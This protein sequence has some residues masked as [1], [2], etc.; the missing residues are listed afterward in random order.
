M[1]KHRLELANDERK[2]RCLLPDCPIGGKPFMMAGGDAERGPETLGSECARC[3]KLRNKL[4]DTEAAWTGL[5]RI[6]YGQ[7]QEILRLRKENEELKKMLAEKNRHDA[8][9][10][11]KNWDRFEFA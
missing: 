3:E 5:Q 7:D 10:L 4:Y 8:E 2:L 6:A 1:H 11:K 9:K